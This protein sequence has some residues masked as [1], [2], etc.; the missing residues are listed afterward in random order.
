MQHPVAQALGVARS[1]AF[2]RSMMRTATVSLAE[3]SPFKL[4]TLQTSSSAVD[5]A[6]TS[7]GSKTFSPGRK[8]GRM[9]AMKSSLLL[10]ARAG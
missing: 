5:I 10:F 6:A 2:A 9:V 4:R 8:N 3:L 1:P 7:L